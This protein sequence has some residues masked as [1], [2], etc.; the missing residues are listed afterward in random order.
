M[1]VCLERRSASFNR[2]HHQIDPI[3]RLWCCFLPGV[4]NGHGSYH[5]HTIW[6]HKTFMAMFIG[7]HT[8]PI[9]EVGTFSGYWYC[10]TLGNSNLIRTRSSLTGLTGNICWMKHIKLVGVVMILLAK[11]LTANFQHQ[12]GECGARCPYLARSKPQLLTVNMVEKQ[13]TLSMI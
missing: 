5:A 13:L 6:K 8:A 4:S 11:L 1:A 3:S 10:C 2:H 9:C 7:M 12:T